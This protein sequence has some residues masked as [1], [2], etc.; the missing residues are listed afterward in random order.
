MFHCMSVSVW[1]GWGDEVSANFVFAAFA[2]VPVLLWA[3]DFLFFASRNFTIDVVFK[4]LCAGVVYG[5]GIFLL[6]LGKFFFFF[7]RVYEDFPG[8]VVGVYFVS[9]VDSV[10]FSGNII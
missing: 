5:R 6:L 4:Y 10:G 3:R 9:P 8:D 1:R 2:F 7:V